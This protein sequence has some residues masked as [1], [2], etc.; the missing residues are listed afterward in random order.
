LLVG[1]SPPRGRGFFY[2]GD[3]TLYRATAP[4]LVE[5]CGFPR[6]PAAF[7]RSFA[8]SGFY[9]DDFSY[10]RGAKPAQDRRAPEVRE[11]VQRIADLITQDSPAVVVG[12]LQSIDTLIDDAVLASAYPDIPCVLLR[13]PYHKS[14]AA[15]LSFQDG[16]RRV[17]RHYGCEALTQR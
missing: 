8:G 14:E 4:V 2:T 1:E 17:V 16:L 13:F 5:E 7:L 12:V 3:S 11:A 6:Q 10:D 15:R 9:L